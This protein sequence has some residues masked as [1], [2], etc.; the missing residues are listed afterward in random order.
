[1][2][3][4]QTR[5]NTHA[6]CCVRLIHWNALYMNMIA[7]INNTLQNAIQPSLP[8]GHIAQQACAIFRKI[9]D[10]TYVQPIFGGQLIFIWWA[11]STH[12]S[13]P[14]TIIMNNK[15]VAELKEGLLVRAISIHS[16]IQRATNTEHIICEEQ[17]VLILRK[18]HLRIYMRQVKINF[19]DNN[20]N[21]TKRNSLFAPNATR[22]CIKV[23]RCDADNVVLSFEPTTTMPKIDY[24]PRSSSPWECRPYIRNSN[25]IHKYFHA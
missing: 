13:S 22:K 6:S 4:K 2:L 18:Y 1:M 14:T 24:N 17:S 16:C 9:N 25:V 7:S 21:C 10:G 12:P 19:N 5:S 23:H 20:N 11:W 8:Y 15:Q 3:D